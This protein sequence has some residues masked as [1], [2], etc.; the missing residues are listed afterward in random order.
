MI[1]YLEKQNVGI[2][3]LS[4]SQSSL[5]HLAES[6]EKKK[7]VELSENEIDFDKNLC[8]LSKTNKYALIS[9]CQTPKGR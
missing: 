3:N 2:S 6:Y 7:K 5:R 8:K 4:L 1:L 9:D